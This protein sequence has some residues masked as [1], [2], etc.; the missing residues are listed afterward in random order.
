MG[1]NV[2][3]APVAS[4]DVP[5]LGRLFAE[6]FNEDLLHLFILPHGPDLDLNIKSSQ[7]RY[8]KDY[9]DPTK[10]FL[11]AIDDAT[12]EVVGFM[13]WTRVEKQGEEPPPVF[14][15]PMNE[16]FCQAVFGNLQK[17]R[18]RIMKGKKCI[19]KIISNASM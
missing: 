6:A 11:K 17:M 9:R 18:V 2:R 8:Q 16:V 19:R 10:H 14:P 15:P 12:G 3:L 7:I 13:T 4:T 1:P 5:I